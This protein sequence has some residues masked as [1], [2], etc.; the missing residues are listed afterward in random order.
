MM[1]K[2]YLKGDMLSVSLQGLQNTFG[3]L[4]VWNKLIIST[5]GCTDVLLFS[6][7]SME[8]GVH[9][10]ASDSSFDVWHDVSPIIHWSVT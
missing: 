8:E 7:R 10:F 9:L 2:F 5:G 1:M 4:F 6:V 3:V